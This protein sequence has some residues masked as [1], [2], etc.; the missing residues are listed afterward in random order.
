MYHIQNAS[1]I[2]VSASLGHDKKYNGLSF[3]PDAF[4]NGPFATLRRAFHAVS[5]LRVT[6]VTRPLTIALMEDTFLEKPISIAP[7]QY[8]VTLTSFGKRR[9][10]VGGIAIT[11]WKWDSFRGVPCLSAQLPPK[12]DGSRWDFTDLLINGKYADLTRYPKQGTLTAEKTEKEG[13]NLF[14]PSKWFIAHKEDLKQVEGLRDAIVN[15]YHFWVDEHSPIESYDEETGKLTMAY[16][17]RFAI[18]TYYGPREHT[19]ALHYY[20]TNVPAMFSEKNQWYLDRD[21]GT[22]YYIPADESI[23][24]ENITA[25]APVISRFFDVSAADFHIRDLELT[26]TCG[27]YISHMDRDYTSPTEAYAYNPDVAYASDIQSVCWAPGA[28]SYVNARR[29]SITDCD[30]RGVGIHAIEIGKGC[31]GIRIERNHMTEI[32]AGGIKIFGGT[33]EEDEETKTTGCIIRGNRISHCGKRYAAGCGVLIGQSAEN[34]IS[35]NEISYLDY[36]GISVG[37]I[38]GY[39]PSSTYGNLITRNHIHHIGLGRLSDMG[40]I[41]LLGKQQGTIVSHNRIHDVLCTH[42]GGWGIYTDEGSS[43]IRIE[44]NVVYN[45]K[46]ECYHQ[47]YGSCNVVRN[48]IFAFGSACIRTS[49]E[50][51]HDGILFEQNL[52]ITNRAPVYGPETTLLPLTSS[53]NLIYDVSGAEPIM[54]Q[55]EDG[56]CYSPEAWRSGCGKDIGSIIANPGFK[57][58]SAFDFTLPDDSPACAIGF[59]PIQGFPAVEE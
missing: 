11:G 20:L 23:T 2:Y 18:N 29:C 56:A 31:R 57:D 9:K 37:W 45:T 48:N 3:T 51:L 41:Y 36:S 30:I 8:A 14:T 15:Y 34:E 53:R 21:A 4:G 6:G 42:Y 58:L 1:V 52:L 25:Y 47:H 7:D 39:A 10:L 27:D 59:R 13:K 55:R 33:A 26:C 35:E 5:D 44:N 40:G 38:W 24:P 50:E 17:S 16:S 49:R 54:L 22:V 43:F 46:S 12:R 32:C 28:I 19:G